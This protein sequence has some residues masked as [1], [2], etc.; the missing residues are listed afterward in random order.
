M[1]KTSRQGGCDIIPIDLSHLV[2]YMFNGYIDPPCA[3]EADV[4]ATGVIDIQDLVALV[5]YMFQG[6][7]PPADCP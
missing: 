5:S 2:S 1:G 7:P 6:G 3:A 4:D